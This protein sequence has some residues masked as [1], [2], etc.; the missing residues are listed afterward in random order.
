M[1]FLDQLK[2]RWKLK[3]LFQV[4]IVLIVFSLTGFT[5]LFIK[6]P[7]LSLI[8]VSE[9]Y[10]TWASVAYYILILPIYQVILL[11]YAFIFGQF[12]FFWEFEKKTFRRVA[13]LFN[14]KASDKSGA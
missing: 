9:A 11:I 12:T 7:L 13:S 14:K 3:N 8:E 10:E 6:E 4:V 2:E 1:G 5:V